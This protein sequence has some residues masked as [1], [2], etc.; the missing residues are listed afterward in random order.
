MLPPNPNGIALAPD[1]ATLAVA[2]TGS[3]RVAIRPLSGAAYDFRD[4]ELG[5]HPDNLL[6]TSRATLFA[7]VHTNGL[8]VLA[9]RFGALPCR[10]PWKLMVIDPR[11]GAVRERL[12]E[13]G[14]RV[15][16][17]ASV[18]EA[19]ARLYFGAVF[20]DRIGVWRER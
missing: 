2:F 20:D 15:G 1:G 19:G 17:V 11:N 8:A 6:W 14:S 5:G 4:V 3:G 10:S 13:A 9:C 16:A 12:D 7:L 18:A